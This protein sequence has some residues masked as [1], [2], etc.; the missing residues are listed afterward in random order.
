MN[1]D[2]RSLTI[3]EIETLERQGCTAEDW[4]RINVVEGFDPKHVND[5]AFHG[6][7]FLGVFD[8]NIEVEE[9][10]AR[11]TGIRHATLCDTTVGDNCLIENIG[12]HIFRYTIGEDCHIANVGTMATTDGA[13]F[14]QAGDV[15]VMD[16]AGEANVFVFDGLTS[17]MAAL[18]VECASDK[19]A[20]HKLRDMVAAYADNRRP[21]QGTIGYRVKIVNTKEIVNANIGDDCEINGATR[22]SECTIISTP[23]AATFIGSDV[24]MDNSIVQPGASVTDGA[25]LSECFVGEACHVGRGF[26]AESSVFFANSYMDNGES[27]AAF[28]GPFSVSHHKSTLLIGGR[29]SFYNAGSTTNFSNHAYKMGPLHHGTLERGSKTASGAHILWPAHIGAFSVCMGKIQS[30]PDTSQLPFSYVIGQP[31][32]STRIV[33]GRNIATV[34]TFRDTA[35]WPRR[36]IRPRS[37]RR[38]LVNFDWLNPMV[39][40]EIVKGRQQLDKLAKEQGENA[41]TYVADGYTIRGTSLRKGMELYDM[42]LTLYLGESIKGH[43]ME[44]PDSATGT[45]QWL[46][47]AGMLAPKA[48]VD[49]LIDDINSGTVERIEQVED[50]L[51]AIHQHYDAYKWNWTYKLI[52][53]HLG[54]D[55]LTEAETADIE[56]AYAKARRQWKEAIRKDAERE[57]ALGDVAQETLDNFLKALEL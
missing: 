4:S 46:D 24:T 16:E 15:A 2:Y 52:T 40:N 23:E 51:A 1:N 7:I 56:D 27:C 17:Q 12:C 43:N 35:K 9:G 47:L 13:T 36:D 19:A 10:F 8:K 38:S 33:P 44:L 30:H 3:D 34:G 22:I 37:G 31:D 11:H 45:G 53:N 39:A 57:F 41:D 21:Q 50:R 26:S 20:A 28:C 18:M 14:G 6:D 25:K 48:E 32:G 42:A 54:I 29:Y 5:V 49:S 55:T